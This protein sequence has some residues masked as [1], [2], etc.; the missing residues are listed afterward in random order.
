MDNSFISYYGLKSQP[1]GYA[2]KS[3]LYDQVQIIVVTTGRLFVQ[4]DGMTD[5]LEPG[6]IALLR[7]GSAFKLHTSARQGYRGV[8]WINHGS[9]E[10][11]FQGAAATGR[12]DDA[13]LS[14]TRQLE[15]EAQ[16]PGAHGNAVLSG[17]GEAFRWM[18]LRCVESKT[19]ERSADDYARYWAERAREQIDANIYTSEPVRSL[20]GTLGLS[21]RQLARHFTSVVGLSPKAYQLQRRI[22]EAKRLLTRSDIP[23]TSIAFELGFP[24]SQHFANQFHRLTQSTPRVYRAAHA[25]VD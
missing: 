10:P 12:A 4:A 11:L 2:F 19:P 15:R 7:R 1:G 25:D 21:Y 23:V 9:G 24:S 14:V 18:A 22:D 20:L 5:R 17:L 6:G 8:F 3:S 13:L 16:A